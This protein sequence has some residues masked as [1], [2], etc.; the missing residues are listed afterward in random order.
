MVNYYILWPA[1]REARLIELHLAGETSR[2]IADEFGLSRNSI[3]G[4]IQRL[5]AAG[6]LPKLPPE[7]QNQ[8]SVA[9]KE[10]AMVRRLKG[11]PTP[12]KPLPKPEPPV[13]G[14]LL[15]ETLEHHCRWPVRGEGYDMKVCGHHKV[16]G[17]YCAKHAKIAYH[18]YR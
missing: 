2:V 8:K 14:I 12:P 3:I 7:K 5:R 9:Q 18:G 6:R 17:A 1:D 13:D 11:A 4:K 15:T 16:T 10:L